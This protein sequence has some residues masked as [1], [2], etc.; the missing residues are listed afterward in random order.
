[1]ITPARKTALAKMENN[2]REN[3][4]RLIKIKTTSEII[5]ANPRKNIVNLRSKL[6]LP[7]NIFFSQLLQNFYFAGI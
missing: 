1:V 5:N 2:T 4:L 6:G 7:K 3:I